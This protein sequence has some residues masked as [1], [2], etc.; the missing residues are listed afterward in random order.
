MNDISIKN[1]F[2]LAFK[3]NYKK[4]LFKKSSYNDKKSKIY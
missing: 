2:Q 1:R 3:K 4:K